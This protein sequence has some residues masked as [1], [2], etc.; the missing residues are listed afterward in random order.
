[1]Q[2]IVD[3]VKDGK[4]RRLIRIKSIEKFSCANFIEMNRSVINFNDSCVKELA[5]GVC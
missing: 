2:R 4:H 1:M 5:S 3:N